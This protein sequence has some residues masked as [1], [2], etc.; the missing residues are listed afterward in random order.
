MRK[1]ARS[2]L[3]VRARALVNSLLV[4]GHFE[5]VAVLAAALVKLYVRTGSGKALSN[6]AK[7]GEGG[8]GSMRTWL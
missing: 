2:P 3:E 6:M 5:E 4:L 7:R 8:E 1:E